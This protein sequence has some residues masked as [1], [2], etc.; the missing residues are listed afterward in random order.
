T[1]PL[2][3]TFALLASFPLGVGQFLSPSSFTGQRVA[4][5][6][7]ILLGSDNVSQACNTLAQRFVD[8]DPIG[9]TCSVIESMD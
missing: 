2:L 7:D 3:D 4:K 8:C 5:K 9:D 1:L 6:L